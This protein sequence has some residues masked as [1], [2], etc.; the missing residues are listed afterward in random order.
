MKIYFGLGSNLGDRLIN[1]REAVQKLSTLGNII[2]TSSVY[3]TQAWGGV[4]QPDYLNACILI[5][6]KSSLEPHEIL[7]QIKTFESQLGRVPSVRWGA[8]KID[9]DILLID[10][11]IYNSPDLIIPHVNLPDRLFVLVPLSEI[12]P[13]KW[14][15][16]QNNKNV[17]E[18]IDSLRNKESW[19]AKI[20]NLL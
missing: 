11:I 17:H 16:P 12:L 15:H 18:M 9:I 6:S 4:S 14:T 1:L 19:P 20:K 8:R 7:T 10:E 3:E 13:E 2:K 5:E